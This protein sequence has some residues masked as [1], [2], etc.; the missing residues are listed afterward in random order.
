MGPHLR[1]ADEWD[2]ALNGWFQG[3]PPRAGGALWAAES[4]MPGWQPQ[5]PRLQLV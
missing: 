3:L 2:L 1:C 5:S 4:T